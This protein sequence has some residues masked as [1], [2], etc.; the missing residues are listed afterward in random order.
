MHF[1]PPPFMSHAPFTTFPCF[2]YP[3][4]ICCGIQIMKFFIMQF[5]VQSPVTSPPPPPSY[6][7]TPVV[8]VV[9]LTRQ[10]KFQTHI[11][12]QATLQ[13]RVF[14]YTHSHISNGK[15]KDVVKNGSRHSPHLICVFFT[16]GI[17]SVSVSNIST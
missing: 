3:N 5:S 4:N 12:W 9:P 17:L 6:S 16:Y 15:T 7:R 2:N 1:S 10:T 13:F 11:K 8:C 14:H